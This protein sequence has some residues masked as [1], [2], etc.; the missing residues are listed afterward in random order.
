LGPSQIYGGP[1]IFKDPGP[2]I[3]RFYHCG[4]PMPWYNWHYG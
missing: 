1:N 3:L 4:G 2:M